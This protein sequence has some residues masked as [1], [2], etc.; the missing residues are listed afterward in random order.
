MPTPD[1]LNEAFEAWHRAVDEHIATMRDVTGGEALDTEAMMLKL[2]EID[3]LHGTWMDMVAR[4]DQA[5]QS[6]LQGGTR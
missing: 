6:A 3:V 2:G 1:K 5:P 4:R